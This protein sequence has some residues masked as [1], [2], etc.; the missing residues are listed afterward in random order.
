MEVETCRVALFTGRATPLRF[1]SHQPTSDLLLVPLG[2]LDVVTPVALIAPLV[3]LVPTRLAGRV[4]GAPGLVLPVILVD[5]EVALALAAL[6][7]FHARIVVRPGMRSKL[8]PSQGR[9]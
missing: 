4:P 6:L 1:Q 8:R 3:R 2:L 9:V 7:R 5:G